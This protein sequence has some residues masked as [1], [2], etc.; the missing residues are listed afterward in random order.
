MRISLQIPGARSL[1]D[2]RQVVRSFKERVRARMDVSIAEIGDVERLQVATFGVC[3]VARESAACRDALE[4]VR[5]LAAGVGEAV[6][7]DVGTEILPFGEGGSEL[8]GGIE[9]A[10]GSTLGEFPVE[11]LSPETFMAAAETPR[12]KGRRR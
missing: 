5:S 8:R 6:L 11:D 7:A 10:L 3:T 2:R 4:K 1:K 9:H 12:A